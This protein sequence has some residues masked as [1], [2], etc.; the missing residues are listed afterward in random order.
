[1]SDVDDDPTDLSGRAPLDGVAGR[2]T[3]PGELGHDIVDE[4]DHAGR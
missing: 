2:Y 4:L 1:M 3:V